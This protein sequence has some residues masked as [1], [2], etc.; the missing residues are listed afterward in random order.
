MSDRAFRDRMIASFAIH[1]IDVHNAYFW[2]LSTPE[3]NGFLMTDGMSEAN[4]VLPA[5]ADSASIDFAIA[6]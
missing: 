6:A 3:K 2:M 4:S 1:A 5:N